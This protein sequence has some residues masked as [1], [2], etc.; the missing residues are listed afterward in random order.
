MLL[1]SLMGFLDGLDDSKKAG[2]TGPIV[3]FC[4]ALVLAALVGFLIYK[5]KRFCAAILGGVGGFFLGVTCYQVFL[6][7]SGVSQ[8]W[9]LILIVAA[10]S[11][12]GFILSWKFEQHALIFGTAFIGSYAFIR[13]VS[14]FAGSYPNEMNLFSKLVAG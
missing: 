12:L 2:L 9:L 1:C 13:G 6:S 14:V 7:S 10:T 8:L 3:S 11:I 5:I 4:V